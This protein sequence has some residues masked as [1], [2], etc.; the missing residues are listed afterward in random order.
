MTLVAVAVALAIGSLMGLLGGGGSIV[1]VPAFTMM[2]GMSA[3]DAVVAS[4]M[5]VGIA[6]AT[7]AVSA[8]LRGVLPLASAS[9][10]GGSAM[11]GATIGGIAGAQLADHVQF[12]ILALVMLLA[13]LIMWLSPAGANRECASAALPM[14]G[15]TGIG[16]GALTGLVGVGGGFLMVPA[17]VIAAGF[18]MTQAAGMSLFVIA[19]SAA[20]A[21]P[22]YA[23]HAHVQWSVVVPLAATSGMAVI[24]AGP[25]APRLPQRLLQQAF[26]VFLVILAT[27]LLLRS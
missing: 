21:L 19:L 23:A 6:A 7:G 4:L 15:A 16:V 17:L 11:I 9:V 25:I 13:A 27:Y 20:A 8:W 2:L 3:K 14:L 26:A 12:T 10:V 18:P 5:V 1:A 22:V 24:A